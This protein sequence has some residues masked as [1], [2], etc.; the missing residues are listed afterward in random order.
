M[1]L[2]AQQAADIIPVIVWPLADSV[3]AITDTI[4]IQMAASS[5]S[6]LKEMSVMN[7]DTNEVFDTV[8]FD[9]S[10]N[11]KRTVREISFPAPAENDYNIGVRTVAWDGTVAICDDK[12]IVNVLMDAQAPTGG[13]ITEVLTQADTYAWTSG[14][15]RFS[16]VAT[17]SMGND[18]VVTVQVSVNG[19]PFVDAT[20]HRDD[21]DHFDG[22]WS[23]AQ[24]V[25]SNPF[26]KTIP[27][28]V[29]IIDKAGHTTMDSASVLVDFDPPPGYVPGE[30]P[31][32]GDFDDDCDVTV[33]DIMLVAFAWGAKPGDPGYNPAFD[34]DNDNEIT[35]SDIM[36]VALHW[37]DERVSRLRLLVL[38]FRPH[39]RP[40]FLWIRRP[41][42][43][44]SMAV[45]M[46]SPSV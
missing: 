36:L 43:G 29:K 40:T 34:V 31:L 42:N 4:S 35:V 28:S 17:D 16:G 37:G 44:H 32:F 21:D 25:G 3:V 41:D 10:D 26:H 27:V 14:I 7:M 22:T 24:Y 8:T 19:G 39:K 1:Q 46:R 20:L 5:D 38:I 11:V 13:L 6:P 15:M 33:T 18:N 12:N 9:Q 23:T 2:S 45:N 30:T